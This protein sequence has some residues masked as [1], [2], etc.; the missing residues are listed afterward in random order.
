MLE[1]II[2]Y[3]SDKI[4][5]RIIVLFFIVMSGTV[6]IQIIFRYFL[7]QPIYWS[8]ELPRVMLIW[9]TFLGA[10]LA[11][12]NRSH[13]GITLLTSR[14][15]IRAQIFVQIVAHF[16]MITFLVILAVGGVDVAML[17]MP[18][19]SAALQMPTGLVYL[20]I[21]VGSLIMILHIIVEIK[22]FFAAL[23]DKKMMGGKG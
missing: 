3:I 2:N 1:K 14:L 6:F 12:K 13:L 18:N 20:A 19:R 21:P 9:L 7:H 16:I 5:A 8:E 23:G 11:M 22:R 10:G 17:T 4:I 15:N